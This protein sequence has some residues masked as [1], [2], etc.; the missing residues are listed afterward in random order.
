MGARS[1]LYYSNAT[2]P[3]PIS[4]GARIFPLFQLLGRDHTD[5]HIGGVPRQSTNTVGASY[6][7]AD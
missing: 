6:C 4:G 2:S 1:A 7:Y 3:M 5:L